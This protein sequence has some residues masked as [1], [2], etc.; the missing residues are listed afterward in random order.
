MRIAAIAALCLLILSPIASDTASWPAP[1][2]PVIP[3]A[4]GYA[5]IPGAPLRPGHTHVYRAI[6]DATLAASKPDRL[7]PALNMAGSELNALGVE[8]VRLANAKFVVVFHGEALAGLLDD[9]HYRS[10]FGVPNPNLAVLSQLKKA[11][12]KLY[13]CGQNLIAENID[14]AILSPD[15]QVASDALLVLMVFQNRGYALMSF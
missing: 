4:D 11:G 1:R 3:A 13:A 10:R 14:P 8:K 6:F 15:V 7:I 5:A 12:V 2:A 9:A